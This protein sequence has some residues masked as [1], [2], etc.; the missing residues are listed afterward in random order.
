MKQWKILFAASAIAFVVN[1]SFAGA[2]R[3]G[4]PKGW[5]GNGAIATRYE[6]GVDEAKGTPGQPAFFINAKDAGKE[7]FGTISQMLD[8]TPYRGKIISLTASILHAGDLGG[9]EIWIR[10]IEGKDRSSISSSWGPLSS[11]W[12]DVRAKLSVPE[13]AQKV[14]IGIGVR[15]Q[16][17]LLAKGLLLEEAPLVKVVAAPQTK[18]LAFRIPDDAA[19]T[20]LKNLNFNE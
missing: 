16:G 11:K 12:E 17:K 2:V 6:T 8:A 14:E 3:M 15:G 10:V 9:Y 1:F 19:T 13:N 5:T 20:S 18:Q 4:I 7:D